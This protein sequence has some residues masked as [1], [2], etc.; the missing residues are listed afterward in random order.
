VLSNTN[1]LFIKLLERK[2]VA[3][4]G[5]SKRFDRRPFTRGIRDSLKL[6]V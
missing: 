4:N 6:V 3:E 5:S 2:V 1:I